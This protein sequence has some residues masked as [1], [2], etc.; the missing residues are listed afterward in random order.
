MSGLTA[1]GTTFNLPNYTGIL[2][3]LTPA[4]T[5]FFSAIGGLSGGQATTSKS[6]EWGVYDLRD[7][8]QNVALEG[9]DAP[10][11]QI[12]VRG[13]ANN[14]TQIHHE[15]TGVSYTKAAAIGDVGGLNTAGKANPVTDEL[16]WQVVQYL[17]IMTRD[18]EYS[19]INGVYQNPAD[20]LTP[21]MTRGL[22][23]AITTNVSSASAAIPGGT[24][25]TAAGA[26][27]LITATGHGLTAGDQVR[28]SAVGTATPLSTTK[29]YYVLPGG[30]TANA[31]KV[32]LTPGGTAVDI[33]ADGTVTVGKQSTVTRQMINSLLQTA[34][35]NGGL[36][37]TATATILT[38]PTLKAAL[39]EAYITGTGA[40][41]RQEATRDVGGVSVSTIITDFGT[42][43][44]MLDRH[45][46]SDTLAV[47]SLEQCRPVYLETPGKGHFFAEPLAKTGAKD[48]IQL[49]G[50]V[51]L[52]Y[53]NEKTHA[54]ITGLSVS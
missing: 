20:N 12:R 7:A 27:D 47:V 22:L 53:G 5:P 39:T 9:Q 37:D 24:G 14:V 36:M 4:D 50:E 26:T 16:D 38:P 10:P 23:S 33:T 15:A 41:M 1:L 31:F 54:K 46:P 42:L 8:G 2:Y 28:F 45:M 3:Q 49:Y 18:I 48:R 17:K 11:D 19:F 29:T 25:A 44:V 51:G 40:G 30:L 34:Y 52:N 6:F 21:R 32:G 43:N 13:T 35:I